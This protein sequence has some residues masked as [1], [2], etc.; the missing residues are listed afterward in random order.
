MAKDDKSTTADKGKGKAVDTPVKDKAPSGKGANGDKK[1]KK[2]E[3]TEG[4]G[5]LREI[6]GGALLTCNRAV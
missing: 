3:V 1:D 4:T 2:D 5:M 6:G